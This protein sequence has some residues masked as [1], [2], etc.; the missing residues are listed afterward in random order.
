M[1]D[2]LNEAFAKF[3][4]AIES[5]P[6]LPPSEWLPKHTAIENLR[7]AV[8]EIFILVERINDAVAAKFGAGHSV[9]FQFLDSSYDPSQRKLQGSIIA[10]FPGKADLQLV[11]AGEGKRISFHKHSFFF[12]AGGKTRSDYG[13]DNV[14]LAL[15]KISAEMVAYFGH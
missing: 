11:L 15:E 1:S 13:A 9:A 12:T 10:K 6:V 2:D 8:P 3:E 7:N 14:S 4:A 5:A